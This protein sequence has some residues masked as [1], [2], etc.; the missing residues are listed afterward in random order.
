MP[1]KVRYKV[2]SDREKPSDDEYFILSSRE[3][4]QEC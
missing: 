2:G 3:L 1:T 4:V